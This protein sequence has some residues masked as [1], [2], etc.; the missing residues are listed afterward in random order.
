MIFSRWRFFQKPNEQIQLYYLYLTC[1]GSCFGRKWRHQK[2]ISKLTDPYDLT[3]FFKTLLVFQKNKKCLVK[4]YR[5]LS[6]EMQIH[7]GFEHI[8]YTAGVA[9]FLNTLF[10]L[11]PHWTEDIEYNSRFCKHDI[12]KLKHMFPIID[13]FGTIFF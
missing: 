13:T 4:L 7:E 6:I 12:F 11:L 10:R 2:D 9:A 3:R 5:H 8:V 1:F